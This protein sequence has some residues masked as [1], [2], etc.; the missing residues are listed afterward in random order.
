MDLIAV[1]YNKKLINFIGYDDIEDFSER[2]LQ[3]GLIK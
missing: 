1:G 2:L 3:D